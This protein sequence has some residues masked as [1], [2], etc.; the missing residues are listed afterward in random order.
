MP[1]GFIT[2]KF[3]SP[4]FFIPIKYCHTQQYHLEDAFLVDGVLEFV[5]NM[6][7]QNSLHSIKR[8]VEST[9]PVHVLPVFPLH[10]LVHCSC[11]V[12]RSVPC[13]RLK[14]STIKIR[15]GS[16]TIFLTYLSLCG[17]ESR[18]AHHLHH[19]DLLLRFAVHFCQVDDRH[20]SLRG[21]LLLLSLLLRLRS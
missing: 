10:H 12:A 11:C 8:S 21:V 16:V 19:G 4:K 17:I 15:S 14:K 1:R 20:G 5:S 2:V 18:E 3:S 9:L 7:S 13:N 6:L